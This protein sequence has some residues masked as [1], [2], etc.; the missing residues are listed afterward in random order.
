MSIFTLCLSSHVCLHI[1]SI[2]IF[3][4]SSHY[5]YLH[6]MSIFTSSLSSHYVYLHI[7]SIFILCLSSH[8]VC[9]HIVSIFTLC[10]SSHYVYLHCYILCRS[11]PVIPKGHAHLSFAMDSSGRT[12]IYV[13][14][15][16]FHGYILSSEAIEPNV[17]WQFI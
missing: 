1:M 17:E 13:V 11:V 4:Q 5:V 9:L 7:V 10:L 16:T 3:S 8:Y 12:H 15:F 6:I 2:F 14:A